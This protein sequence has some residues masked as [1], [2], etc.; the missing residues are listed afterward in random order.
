MPVLKLKR[1]NG[2]IKN[3]QLTDRRNLCRTWALSVFYNGKQYW[4]KLHPTNNSA[5]KVRLADGTILTL[6][7]SI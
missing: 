1:P 3:I 7:P 6:Q 2:E 4:A 5:G